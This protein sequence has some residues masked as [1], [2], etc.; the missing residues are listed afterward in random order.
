M[1]NELLDGIDGGISDLED[2][3]AGSIDE[4]REDRLGLCQGE[5]HRTSIME[6]TRDG[7]LRLVVGRRSRRRK[8]LVLVAEPLND[9]FALMCEFGMLPPRRVLDYLLKRGYHDQPQTGIGFRRS[10]SR[11]R[12]ELRLGDT[13]EIEIFNGNPMRPRLHY[14]VGAMRCKSE[15]SRRV[16][17]ES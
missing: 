3:G 12:S 11:A 14:D 16:F 4:R 2:A 9:G 6:R 7:G 10:H 17:A 13:T 8:M 1:R 15:L 5:L